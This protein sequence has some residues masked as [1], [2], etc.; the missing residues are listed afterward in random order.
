M[1]FG[2]GIGYFNTGL[3]QNLGHINIFL[4][5]WAQLF[6]ENLGTRQLAIKLEG[7]QLTG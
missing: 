5:L 4:E 7:T 1:T 2:T 3:V 6:Q